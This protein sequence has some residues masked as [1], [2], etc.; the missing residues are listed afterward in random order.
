MR[1][2]D[3]LFRKKKEPRIESNNPELVQA[4]HEIASHDDPDNRKRLYEALLSPMLWVPV[5]EVPR[6]LVAG[7]QVTEAPIQ[8]QITG[9]T[10]RN[11]IPI[12]PAFTDPEALRNWDP[13]T[14]HLAIKARELF[15][16]VMESN[17]QAIIINPY[18]PIRKMIRPGGRVTRDE[19]DLLAKGV[20]PSHAG[21]RGVQFRLKAND[22][23]AISRPARPPSE[24]I[25]ELL[26]SKA[27]SFPSV[28]ELYVFQMATQGGIQS[29]RYRNQPERR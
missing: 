27:K 2:L 5:P 15:R 12:T 16:F 29:H 6:E 24:A 1:I 8:L 20:I 14:P 22:K 19:I 25:E 10:D 4:M 23:I 3:S 11:G 18:D 28:A 9:I 26:R 21:P 7:A 17:I 13:N